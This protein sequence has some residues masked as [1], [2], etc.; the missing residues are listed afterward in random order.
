MMHD[1]EGKSQGS[2]EVSSSQQAHKTSSS[3]ICRG[4][5]LAFCLDCVI[6]CSF[7]PGGFGDF[8]RR[9]VGLGV[10]C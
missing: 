6:Q 8:S 1:S 5:L 7:R 4:G 2:A 10:E 3:D 9:A